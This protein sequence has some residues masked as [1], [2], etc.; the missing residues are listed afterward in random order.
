MRL[1]TVMGSEPIA[2]CQ[3]V[4]TAH[5]GLLRGVVGASALH[6]YDGI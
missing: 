4:S 5:E 2:W 1:A 6:G 3:A